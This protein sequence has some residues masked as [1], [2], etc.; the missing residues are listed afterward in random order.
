MSTRLERGCAKRTY[1]S[2]RGKGARR[3]AE[4]GAGPASLA[5]SCGTFHRWAAAAKPT[6]AQATS[7]SRRPSAQT[8]SQPGR[9]S[10]Q[11][12]HVV[13]R[14]LASVVC[15]GRG[16][17]RRAVPVFIMSYTLHNQLE[18]GKM[19]CPYAP[20][21]SA[22]QYPCARSMCASSSIYRTRSRSARV[23]RG[24]NSEIY[25]GSP[26][27]RLVIWETQVLYPAPPTSMRASNA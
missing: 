1:E 9:P 27:G 24:S 5:V 22:S 16:A 21:P 15:R 26:L 13:L 14:L 2:S 23:Q 20:V 17:Q 18:G 10:A 11:A 8:A 25:T 6:S 7:Q 4:G 19:T 12:V 3:C